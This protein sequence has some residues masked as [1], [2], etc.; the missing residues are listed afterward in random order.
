M[1][2]IVLEDNPIASMSEQTAKVR[3]LAGNVYWT[4]PS[5]NMGEIATAESKLISGWSW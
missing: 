1:R 3:R 5:S 2:T 4:R